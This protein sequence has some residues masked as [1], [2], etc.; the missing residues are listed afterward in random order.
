MSLRI[1]IVDDDQGSRDFLREMLLR[2]GHQVVGE[3]SDGSDAVGL[4]RFRGTKPDLVFMD[5]DMPFL[6]GLNAITQL[7]KIHSTAR[8][9]VVT[10]TNTPVEEIKSVG[11][12]G[13]V[14]KP[15]H[16]E[17]IK[18][19]LAQFEVVYRETLRTG[20]HSKEPSKPSP[21]PRKMEP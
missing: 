14:R 16:P 18:N 21:K 12:L 13:V 9:I 17:T 2:L 11:A 15:C 3:V 1:L 19:I 8:I 6:D 4:Y 20:V 10:G 7:R 5:I